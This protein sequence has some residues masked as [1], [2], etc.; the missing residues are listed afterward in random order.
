MRGLVPDGDALV[1]LPAPH[2][3]PALLQQNDDDVI[4]AMLRSLEEVVSG[5]TRRVSSARVVRFD[6]AYTLFGVG[7]LR[8]IRA[9]D[10]A[11]LPRGIALA[12]DY[13]VAPT[14]EGAVRSGRAAASQL[15][16]GS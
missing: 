11:W 2:A 6:D 4:A 16:A 5:I 14:V 8:A 13:L 10:N 1:A 15:L 7:H 9:F 12:G 3:V